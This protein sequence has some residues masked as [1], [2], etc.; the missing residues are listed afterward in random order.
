MN[1]PKEVIK[2]L[3]TLEDNGYE[4]YVVG[5]AIRNDILGLL[6][7]DYDVCTSAP[8]DKLED[9]FKNFKLFQTGLKSGTVTVI[10]NSFHIEVTTYRAS[11]IEEDLAMRDFT[12]NS[13]CYNKDYFAHKISFE[14]LENKVI[15]VWDYEKTFTLDPL[16]ILRAIRLS[17]SYGFTIEEETI[18]CM[19]RYKHLLNEVASERIH[20]EF[21]KIIMNNH[22][23]EAIEKYFEIFTE[24]IPELVPLKGF[25]QNNPY[26]VYDVLTHTLVALENSEK[27]LE[28]R[29]ALLLHDIGKPQTFT[30]V[31]GICHFYGHP[32]VGVKIASEILNRLKF[33]NERKQIIKNLIEYHDYVIETKKKSVRKILNKVG[34]NFE[35]LL[36]V[37]RCDILAQNLEYVN[38]L[39]VLEEI[40]EIGKEVI[41]D[42]EGY[43]LKTL[44]ITGRDVMDQGHEGKE[45]GIVLK[46]VLEKVI[47]GELENKREILTDYVASMKN[48]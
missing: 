22:P 24:F 42:S 12:I 21:C 5:G 46:D 10:L 13:I 28:V 47:N 43:N 31:D 34:D 6:P 20:D 4:S 8:L 15:R 16:R 29:I 3:D 36:E 23:K 35:K 39:S 38:R 26:H 11:T 41:K 44:A 1:L 25:K 48:K 27:D 40:E 2:V 32:Q 14:D 18:K 30:E 45:I 19:F 7:K 17:C 9:I 33:S 37:K